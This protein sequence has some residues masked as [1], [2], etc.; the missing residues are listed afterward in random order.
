[1]LRKLLFSLALV[2]T[3][4]FV[5][6]QTTTITITPSTFS[7]PNDSDAIN[8]SATEAKV[9]Q[10]VELILPQATAL[11]LDA[12]KIV[13]DL[14]ALDGDNWADRAAGVPYDGQSDVNWPACISAPG[15]DQTNS[16]LGYTYWNQTQTQPGSTKYDVATWPNITITGT[17]VDTYPPIKLDSDGEL[18]EGSKAYFVCYQS[19][20]IQLFSNFKYW[21]LSV[22]RADGQGVQGIEHLYV[23]GN[24]CSDFG[25]ATGLYALNNNTT[26]HLIP[27]RTGAGNEG[28]TGMAAIKPGSKCNYADKSWLD[29]LGVL[30]VKVNSD[31]HGTSVANLT[32]TLMSQDTQFQ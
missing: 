2:A 19:F 6:A 8:K 3:F 12:T 9:N 7:G 30:A 11:H 1:M 25:D 4:G 32:Y 29:V 16:N 17:A 18:V 21:D 22:S 28:T 26:V 15:P 23:Q 27:R 14:E 24:T 31:Y 10:T 20:I 5:F 13:F